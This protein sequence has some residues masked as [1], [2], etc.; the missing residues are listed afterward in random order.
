MFGLLIILSEIPFKVDVRCIS[1]GLYLGV[2]PAGI[3]FTLFFYSISKLKT[4][5]P[6]IIQFFAPLTTA[7]LA[8]VGL[9][10]VITFSTVFGGILI[11]IGVLFS[12]KI[13]STDEKKNLV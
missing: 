5:I 4:V 6:G 13:Q 11:V 8:M 7:V 9:K 10:Q 2:V 3:G 12:L 1:I